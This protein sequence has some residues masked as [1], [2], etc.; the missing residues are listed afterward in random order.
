[1]SEIVSKAVVG[2]KKALEE[3]KIILERTIQKYGAEKELTY[4]TAYELPLIFAF[5]G[6]SSKKLSELKEFLEQLAIEN[7]TIEN[8][9]EDGLIT[10]YCYEIQEAIKNLEQK[11][12]FIPDSEIRRLGAPLVDGTIIGITIIL[13]KAENTEQANNLIE[14]AEKNNLLTFL[15]GE[16]NEQITTQLGKTVIKLGK[17]KSTITHAFNTAA[18]IGLMFGHIE[19]AQKQKITEYIQKKVPAFAIKLGK[20]D[21]EDISI[22]TAAILL[23]IPIITNQ[24]TETIAEKLER[25]TNP[26]RMIKRGME[27]KGIKAKITNIDIPLLFSQAFEGQIIRKPDTYVEMGG[28]KTPS[29]EL[30]TM[31]SLEELEDGKIILEGPD[32]KDIQEGSQLPIALVIEVAGRKMQ[33]EYEP[34][35]ERRIHDYVNYADGLWHV[36]QRNFL[37]LRVSKTAAKKGFSFKHYGNIIRTKF[38]QDYGGI[39]DKVQV[40]IYTNEK[41]NELMR[42]ALEK[43]K[44]RDERVKEMTDESV[45]EFYTCTLCQAFAPD[46]VCIITPE[47]IGLCGTVNWLDAKASHEIKPQGHNRPII[48]E[49]CENSIKGNWQSVNKIVKEESHGK[50]EQFNM[51]SIMENPCTSCGCFECIAAI[52]PEANGVMLVDRE[53]KGLTPLGTSFITLAGTVGG[54]QQAP[55]FLGI[56][57]RYLL[58]KKFLQAEG[59]I[60]RIVWAT[61]NIKKFLKEN[62]DYKKLGLEQDF[63]DK[64]ADET[65]ANNLQEVINF[66]VQKNHPAQQMK[67]L[68]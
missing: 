64:I 49:K 31:K 26:E 66:I 28:G 17:E 24:E 60:K 39:V 46:H 29:F 37:W 47:R 33:K 13:G 30:V 65:N 23:G 7:S 5:T 11:N 27:I 58:T 45:N 6:K 18:R 10:L 63:I 61:T 54:G 52:L 34:I 8:A 20:I 9:M 48:K 22:A 21:E 12:S 42:T 40:K 15:S 43:Y 38:L 1:M 36:A 25:E 4:D 14:E 53:F 55:G 16:I 57:L 2:A 41:V 59:G 67:Q 3:T 44:E 68:M 50:L 32:I 35:L 51:Y 19:R 62:I 56:G